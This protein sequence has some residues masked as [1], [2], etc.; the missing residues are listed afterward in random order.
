MEAIVYHDELGQEWDIQEI[1]ADMKDAPT[2]VKDMCGHKLAIQKGTEEARKNQVTRTVMLQMIFNASGKVTN[3]RVVSGLPFGLTEKAISAARK[4]YF[5]PAI[6]DG[7]HVS[8]Y[9]R[10]EY[11]FN[12]Y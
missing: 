2:T 7:K 11:N 6:K 10:V 1:P 3:I 5:I 8:Q 9:I 4:I 12:I